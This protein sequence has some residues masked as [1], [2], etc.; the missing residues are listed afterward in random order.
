MAETQVLLVASSGGHLLE[1]LELAD[2]YPPSTRQWVTFDKPDARVLLAGERV[3]FAYGPTN[4]HLGNLIRNALLAFQVVLRTRPRAVI[5]TGAG[6]AVP[7]L[8]AARLL[9]HRAIYVES[10]ARIDQLSLS[11]RLVYP[12][13]THFFVQWPELA[14]RY[15]RGRYVGAIL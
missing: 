15:R 8:Y 4:R 11:G 3:T 14:K 2:E 1:L 5:T 9:R 10:L 12:V 13:A 6:V 7:F